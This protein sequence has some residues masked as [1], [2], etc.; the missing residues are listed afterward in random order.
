M[1]RSVNLPVVLYG[2]LTLKQEQRLNMSKNIVLKIM[3]APKRKELSK[4]RKIRNWELHNLY[5]S[6]N[7]IRIIILGRMMVRDVASLGNVRNSY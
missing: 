1:Q 6:P 4:W 3:F 2:C 7:I 5:S